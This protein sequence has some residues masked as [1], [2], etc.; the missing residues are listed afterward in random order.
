MDKIKDKQ[1]CLTIRGQLKLVF[2]VVLVSW[3]CILNNLAYFAGFTNSYLLVFLTVTLWFPLVG[4]SIGCLMYQFHKFS[5][6]GVCNHRT[7]LFQKYI[8]YVS[9]VILMGSFLYHKPWWI[10]HTEGLRDRMI[11][12]NFEK[13]L[14]L[15]REWFAQIGDKSG[16]YPKRVLI[17]NCPPAIKKLRPRHVWLGSADNNADSY[18]EILGVTWAGGFIGGWG[19]EIGPE[20]MNIPESSET[21]YILPFA[22]GAY[23]F[24]AE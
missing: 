2:A 9:V 17:E 7:R 12:M 6:Y 3:L 11:R 19:I 4:G 13:E 20:S 15:I 24:H 1:K 14:P 10:R 5:S 22:P 16:S 18:V 23:V 8:L 21:Q